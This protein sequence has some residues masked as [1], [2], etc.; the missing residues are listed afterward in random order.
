MDEPD[1]MREEKQINYLGLNCFRQRPKP[2]EEEFFKEPTPADNM[3]LS[4]SSSFVTFDL[5]LD[6]TLRSTSD[7]H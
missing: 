5:W 4:L 6:L 3:L 7:K 1:K 2:K